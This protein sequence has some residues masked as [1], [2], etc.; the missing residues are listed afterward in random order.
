MKY[1]DALLKWSIRVYLGLFL[2]YL[3]FPLFYLMLLAFNSSRIPT[4]RNFDFT[5]DWFGAAWVDQRMWDGLYTSLLI[6]VVVVVLSVVL[7]LGG[8]LALVRLDIRGK[9][10]L[11]A[12]LVSPILAP[13]IVL[14]ISTF[15]FWSQQVGLRASWWTA[16]LAQTSFIAAYCMLIFIAR[17][18]RFDT[19]LEE[20]GLDLGANPRQVFWRITLPYMRPALLS[21][22]GLAFLQSFENYTTTYFAIGAEQTFAIFIANKVRQGVTPAVNAVA[23]VLV[24][25]TI[26]VAIA[27]EIRRRGAASRAL[28]AA[29]LAQQADVEIAGALRPQEVPSR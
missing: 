29:R 22:A 20:A 4:H 7:G 12:V 2:G 6:A 28:E 14:G 19:T 26:A 16:A 23:F 10:L 11:Y 1:P 24:V 8:A 13:G 17:L 18:Q 9:S 27:A 15:I 5:L 21:A 25:T 3:L